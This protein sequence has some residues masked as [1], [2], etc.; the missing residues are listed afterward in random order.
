MS[1]GFLKL[2]LRVMHGQLL[3][4]ARSAD[5]KKYV[6]NF[7]CVLRHLQICYGRM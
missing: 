3:K 2:F 5:I 1:V 6:I 4:S 7:I